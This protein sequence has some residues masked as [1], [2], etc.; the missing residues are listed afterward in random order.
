MTPIIRVVVLEAR[1]SISF[2]DQVFALYDSAIPF[3]ICRPGTDPGAYPALEV[4]RRISPDVRLGWASPRL[5]P[6]AP[7]GSAIA[8]VVF[9][10][11]TEGRPKAIAISRA[12]LADVEDR[13]LEVMEITDEIREYIGVPVSYSFGLG[14]ARVVAR[15]G[16]SFFLPE[17]FDPVEIREM[18]AA[19]E[20]NAISAVP[21]LW[22]LLLAQPGFLGD[23]GA[24]VRWIEIG[25]Q[26]M[27]GPEKATLREIFPR[28]RIVQHYG[29]TEASRTSF[30]RIDGAA[31]A[32]LDSVGQTH[33]PDRGQDRARGGNLHPRAASGGG[34]PWR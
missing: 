15:A 14:R 21:S 20:I 18:L 13:L 1:N 3:A 32:V 19:G 24:R 34:D 6:A 8:Q 30:L 17:R 12:A 11:G 33:R 23:L 22:R 9:S 29:L 2:V 5:S 10:S 16:G 7:Q 27:S 31:E 4:M 26:Y 25:S 28:A